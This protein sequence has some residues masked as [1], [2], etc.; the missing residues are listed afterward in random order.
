MLTAVGVPADD[1]CVGTR[2]VVAHCDM[3]LSGVVLVVPEQQSKR[4]RGCDD[5]AS[6]NNEE[7]DCE[8]EVAENDET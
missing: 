6:P 2:C 8:V 7:D 1:T 5:A 4:R 3:V